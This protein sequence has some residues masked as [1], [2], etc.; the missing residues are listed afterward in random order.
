MVTPKASGIAGDVT[1]LPGA[2]GMT[3]SKP[4]SSVEVLSTGSADIVFASASL[5][6]NA[7]LLARLTSIINAAYVYETGVFWSQDGWTRTNPDEVRTLVQGGK[8]ALAWKCGT[9]H[10]EATDLIGCVYVTMLDAKTGDFGMLVCDSEHQGAGIGRDLLR[11][12]ETW[13]KS[14]GADAM[15]L[16][17]LFPDGWDSPHKARL[18][19]W[20]ERLGYGMVRVEAIEQALGRMAHLIAQPA[21]VRIYQKPL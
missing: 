7:A 8:L 21:V 13:A 3:E 4:M 20:Y 18:A 2:P 11:Y 17:L 15:Q 12:A 5:A 1:G 19:R 14:Q 9:G 10:E 6:H 16:E